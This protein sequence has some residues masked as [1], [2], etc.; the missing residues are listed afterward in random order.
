MPKNERHPTK[1]PGVYY[2]R[3]FKRGMQVKSEDLYKYTNE[4]LEKRKES[5]FYIVYR[6]EGR[7]IE[8]KAKRLPG[9]KMTASL[10]NRVRAAK[11]EG[12][13]L[14]NGEI[15]KKQAA[16]KVK[17]WTFNLLWEEYKKKKAG[18]KGLT[19]DDYCYKRNVQPRIGNKQPKDLKLEEVEDICTELKKTLGPG[20]I[21]NILYLITRAAKFGFKRNLCPGLQFDMSMVGHKYNAK[22][23]NFEYLNPEQYK[24]LMAAIEEDEH[25]QA[26]DMMKLALFTGLRKGELF[27][28][29]WDD[30]DF[31]RGYIDLPETKA[32][33]RQDIPLNKTTTELL[34]NHKR[35]EG[36]PYVFPNRHGRQTT[37]LDLRYICDKAGLPSRFRPLHDLRHSYASGMASSG[38]VD[39]YRLQKLLRHATPAMTERYAHLADRAM[40]DA[41]EV[42]KEDMYLK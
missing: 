32:G 40:R 36:C 17:A 1:Y 9:E 19:R 41:A 27:R 12:R 21:R 30:I 2:I 22:D 5:V 6:L 7:K 35:V 37:Q 14:P 15:R 11:L 26:G 31:H 23:C 39:L 25:P 10:A 33:E 24:A 38:K 18:N 4:E 29:R 34:R 28:L 13:I 16:E 42:A 20:S 8:E 3:K